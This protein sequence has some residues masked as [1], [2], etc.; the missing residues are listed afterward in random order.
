VNYDQYLMEPII[1]DYLQSLE[2]TI[3]QANDWILNKVTGHTILGLMVSEL[4]CQLNLRS[5]DSNQLDTLKKE[6]KLAH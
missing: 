3:L 2:N 4:D 1:Q 6:L 5:Y